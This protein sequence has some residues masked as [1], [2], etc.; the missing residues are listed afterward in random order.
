MINI[1]KAFT[2][3][4]A[5]LSATALDL[6]AKKPTK[7]ADLL[8]LFSGNWICKSDD[9]GFDE[10]MTF[11]V[12]ET[13]GLTGTLTQGLGP[14]GDTTLDFKWVYMKEDPSRIILVFEEGSKIPFTI[15]DL[16]NSTLET[17]KGKVYNK[18]SR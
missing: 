4:I 15:V 5:L 16:T 11:D 1:F 2:L 6:S 8:P 14:L 7:S 9:P 12:N 17:D 13:D 18:R 10:I 3:T